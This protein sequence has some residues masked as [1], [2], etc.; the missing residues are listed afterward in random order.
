MV[1]FTK[2]IQRC[3]QMVAHFISIIQGLLKLLRK[4]QI[5]TSDL[6]LEHTQLKVPYLVVHL[7][8]PRGVRQVTRIVPLYT[9]Q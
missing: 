4:N 7:L 5:E 3:G 9:D 8:A 6:G 1:G 2:V